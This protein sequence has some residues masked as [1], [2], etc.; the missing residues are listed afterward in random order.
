M[1]FQTIIAKAITEYPIYIGEQLLERADFKKNNLVMIMDSQVAKVYKTQ[2]ETLLQF[3]L[4]AC[5]IFMIISL[6]TRSYAISFL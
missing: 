2:F 5:L 3:N 1:K 6:L 4:Q